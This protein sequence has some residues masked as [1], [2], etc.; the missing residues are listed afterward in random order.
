MARASTFDLHVMDT[1]ARH[2][3]YQQQ[4]AEMEQN[5]K[6]GRVRPAAPPTVEQMKDMVARAK[7]R[8]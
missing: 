4:R 3:R 6:S 1:A 8:G 5:L 2:Q 7:E